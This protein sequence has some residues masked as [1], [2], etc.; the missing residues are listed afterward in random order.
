MSSAPSSFE[1]EPVVLIN[2]YC[3]EETR[4]A[5]L[6]EHLALMLQTQRG[7]DGFISATLHR[8]LNGRT[9]AIHSVWRSRT[10]WK[11]MARH[12]SIMAR[13]EPIMAL[14]TFEPNLY[15]PGEVID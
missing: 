9:A 12:P 13:L 7:M 14:A 11:V 6:M 2:V 1:D 4:Q 8:G 15:E 3:C 10:D 5:E